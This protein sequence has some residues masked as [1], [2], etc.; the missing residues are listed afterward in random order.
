MDDVS[1]HFQDLNLKGMQKA[2][3]FA[4]LAFGALERLAALNLDVWRRSLAR[5]ETECR[6]LA[7]P[8]AGEKLLAGQAKA[9]G[10]RSREMANYAQRVMLISRET[11]DAFAREMTAPDQPQGLRRK[12]A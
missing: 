8:L 1:T 6:N 11:G 9:V 10:E 5:R 7:G 3:V 2:E 12:D 4:R